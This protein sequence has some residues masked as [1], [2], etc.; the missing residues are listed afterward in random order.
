LD[1]A[2]A[3][4]TEDAVRIA[5]R[6]QQIAA[7]ETGVTNTIDP[8]GGSYFV[9]ALTDELERQAYD[10]FRQI[11]EMG[12][13]IQA[14]ER[15]SRCARSPRPRPLPRELEEKQRYMVNVNVYEPQDEQDVELHRIDP[16]VSRGQLE[17]LEELKRRRDNAE[18]ARCLEELKRAA[19]ATR[20]RCT[21]SWTPSAP[22]RRCRRFLTP[23]RRSSATTERRR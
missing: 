12:G 8:L 9:E 13:M 6:T 11:D 23:S 17:R 15:A 2:L 3:L 21:R 16:E 19:R 7:L 1:E 4:P 14:I 10:Y 18:V 20:T 22:T 5:V